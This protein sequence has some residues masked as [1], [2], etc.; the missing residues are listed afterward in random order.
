MIFNLD[1]GNIAIPDMV[2]IGQRALVR[3]WSPESEPYYNVM[4]QRGFLGH[5]MA[6]FNKQ[7]GAID[8][9]SS[10]MRFIDGDQ[11]IGTPKTVGEMLRKKGLVGWMST[12]TDK[13]YDFTRAWGQMIGLELA[14]HLGIVGMDNQVN[15]AHD[16]AN[17]MIANYAPHNRPEVFQGAI[18][19]TLGLFQRFMQEYYQRMFRYVETKDHAALVNQF[20]MQGTLFGINSLPGFSQYNQTQAWLD[21]HGSDPNFALR[22]RLG[23]NAADFFQHGVLANIPTLMGADGISVNTRGDAQL[24]V[25]GVLTLPPGLQV[26]GRVAGGVI[27]AANAFWKNQGT[28][29]RQQMAEILA[30]A[31]PNRPIAGLIQ[32]MSGG[33]QVD[34]GGQLVADTTSNLEAVYRVLGMHSTRQQ[35]Q[36]DAYYANRAAQQHKAAADG[37]LR[38][39]TRAAIR[40]GNTDAV[41]AIYQKYVENGG[42]PRQ[43]TKWLKENQKAATSTRGARQLEQDLKATYKDPVRMGQIT[44]LLDSGVTNDQDADANGP[45]ADPFNMATPDP[46]MNQPTGYLGV[47][48]GQMT[49]AQP[50]QPSVP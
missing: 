11:S 7:F 4:V 42:D 33:D 22:D 28:M 44:R 3:A 15:F 48:P 30:N 6:E 19:S 2:K 49:M 45:G 50:G 29:T 46:T 32:Q 18:G 16:I 34:A 36:V 1:K 20:V 26:A 43:F 25:P 38:L 5:E 24:R 12:L 47:Y 21:K 14:D 39:A 13:S 17:K 8:S 23:K 9:K 37:M 10:L 31:M 27:A 35:D 41:P 40:E